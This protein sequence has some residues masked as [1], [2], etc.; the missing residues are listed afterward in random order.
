MQIYIYIN[1]YIYI[2]K[3]H[4]KHDKTEHIWK[5]TCIYTYIKSLRPDPTKQSKTPNQILGYIDKAMG[6]GL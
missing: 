5:H 1:I 3:K 4:I 6:S 2:H